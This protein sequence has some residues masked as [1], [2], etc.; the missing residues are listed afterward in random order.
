MYRMRL[1]SNITACLMALVFVVSSSSG[2]KP[3]V[4]TAPDA[5]ETG[6]SEA[7]KDVENRRK[8]R[9]VLL[10]KDFANRAFSFEDSSNKILSIARFADL[11][12]KEDEIHA[13]QLFLRALELCT[14][15]SD[16]STADRE[17]L[18][19]LRREL[20][21]IISTR[22]VALAKQ[23]TKDIESSSSEAGATN[24][25]VAQ[26]LLKTEPEAAVRFAQRS[27]DSGI[28]MDLVFFLL[29]LR[30]QDQQMA[31][32]LY[33]E[34]LN[35]V[36]VMKCAGPEALIQLGTYVFT[37]SDQASEPKLS[38]AMLKYV[39]IGPVLLPDIS[40]E[41]P[42]VPP[43][44]V[45]AY[46]E[47]AANVLS[48]PMCASADRA[49][50]YAAS[51]LLLNKANRLAPDLSSRIA[52]SMQ[53]LRDVVPRE[54]TDESTYKSETNANKT[55]DETLAE[56]EGKPDVEYRDAQYFAWTFDL[57]RRSDFDNARRVSSRISDTNLRERLSRMILFGEAARLLQN[58]TKIDEAERIAAKLPLGIQRAL[59]RLG[60]AAVY[61]QRKNRARA[62][63]SIDEALRDA[64]RLDDN[65]VPF[66]LLAAASQLAGINSPDAMTVLA[67]SVRKLNANKPNQE[68]LW[69]EE[70]TCGGLWRNWPLDVK[71]VNNSFAPGLPL[72]MKADADVT[73]ETILKISDEKHLS[74]A[75]LEVARLSLES[76]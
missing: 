13:R 58:E 73:V 57:W 16:A 7:L 33:L 52:A 17:R 3:S 21:A 61:A 55:L 67:E 30:A 43:S 40:A 1:R 5:N 19:R 65:R 4:K 6:A 76:A 28:S 68:I 29:R 54:L 53:S 39:G 72:L 27:L 44:L 70:I 2:Q 47:A 24:L 60:L 31:N 37:F 26:R 14:P 46:L 62:E 56:I 64:R 51:Y 11:L 48:N 23:L 25:R 66:L 15:A 74:Q 38:P 8:Q 12:W 36:A 18:V 34:V 9:A 42:E 41:R 75:L 71:G 20:V 22:D 59:L 50:L 32:R 10:V 35:R 45:R 63:E 69:H 49:Q